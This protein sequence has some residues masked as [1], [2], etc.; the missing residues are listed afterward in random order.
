MGVDYAQGYLIG[1]PTPL[2]RAENLRNR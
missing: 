2:T 1:A